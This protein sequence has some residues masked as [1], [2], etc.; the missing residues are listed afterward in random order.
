MFLVMRFLFLILLMFSGNAGADVQEFFSITIKDHRFNPAS[1]TVPAG[2]RVKLVIDNQDPTPEEFESFPLNRE[3]VIAGGK[4]VIIF[5]GPLKKGSYE[6]IG[7]FHQKT[8]K[9]VLTAE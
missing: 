4:Q 8:A 1:L 7:E 6:F 3:K 2:K 9:G 5:V